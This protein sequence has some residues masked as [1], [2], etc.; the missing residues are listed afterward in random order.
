MFET[1][2]CVSMFITWVCFPMKISTSQFMITIMS[3]SIFIILI[4]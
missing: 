2:F 4:L 3:K 1:K